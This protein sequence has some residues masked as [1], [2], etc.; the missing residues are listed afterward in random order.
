MTNVIKNCNS[1]ELKYMKKDT[2]LK[3]T[4]TMIPTMGILWKTA[5]YIIRETLCIF[6]IILWKIFKFAIFLPWYCLQWPKEKTL[7]LLIVKDKNITQCY[8][9]LLTKLLSVFKYKP[10][11][12]TVPHCKCSGLDIPTP[13]HA[14]NYQQRLLNILDLTHDKWLLADSIYRSIHLL[15]PLCF[16]PIDLIDYF[17]H[18]KVLTFLLSSKFQL[19]FVQ[20]AYLD[21]YFADHRHI[22]Q[23]LCNLLPLLMLKLDL[24]LS[25][26][27]NISASWEASL[28]HF[29]YSL[30]KFTLW[31][32]SISSV[33]CIFTFSQRV[34]GDFLYFLQSPVHLFFLKQGPLLAWSSHIR[35]YW[36]AIEYWV[37]VCP[38]IPCDRKRSSYQQILSVCLC[39]RVHTCALFWE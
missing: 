8:I 23:E 34:E 2:P 5:K 38:H 12:L 18:S 36:L 3:W 19:R 10:P 7:F 39:V 21:Y 26:S 1:W 35:L 6:A 11:F 4:I 33:A 27:F 37:F 22:K 31:T 24:Y 28:L 25:D 9:C 17:T 20:A 15:Q 16:C 14:L 13:H 29:K 30:S 32:S